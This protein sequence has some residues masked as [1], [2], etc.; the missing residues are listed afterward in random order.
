MGVP[1]VHYT[2]DVLFYSSIRGQEYFKLKIFV[3]ESN[4]QLFELQEQQ[5]N[6]LLLKQAIKYK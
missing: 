5:S 3:T 4:L 2:S 1:K 6:W